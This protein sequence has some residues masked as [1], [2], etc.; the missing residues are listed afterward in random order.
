ME[1]ERFVCNSSIAEVHSVPDLM[2]YKA[3]QD[4]LVPKRIWIVADNVPNKADYIY[5]GYPFDTNSQGFAGRWLVFHVV[6]QEVAISLQG[7][8]HS[9]ADALL[10]HTGI[11][12]RDLYMVQLV[13]GK[14]F[15]EHL[16]GYSRVI[17]D[18]IYNEPPHVGR[19][20]EY[21]TVLKNIMLHDS[22]LESV[23]YWHDGGG[24]SCTAMYTRKDYAKD[25]V[26]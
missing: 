25:C 19:Y 10:E 20:D 1:L 11:D 5:V 12:V 23:A 2:W 14:R 8:W 24:G 22:S 26:V 13:V 17:E 9:N 6:D 16:E 7:P 3:Y 15:A 18:I 4:R 21:K